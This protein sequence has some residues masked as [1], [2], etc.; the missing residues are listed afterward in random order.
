MPPRKRSSST[1]TEVGTASTAV[2]DGSDLP[3]TPAP[4]T[5][6]TAA[7]PTAEQAAQQGAPTP[8]GRHEGG[9]APH[10]PA[11]ED[12]TA[13]LAARRRAAKSGTIAPGDTLTPGAAPA[14]VDGATPS[15]VMVS[16]TLVA[17]HYGA[18]GPAR[19]GIG[20][21][22][23][24]WMGKPL[25]LPTAPRGADGVRPEALKDDGYVIAD[26]DASEVVI[27]P[28]A[29]TPTSRLLWRKG[30]PVRADLYR[31]VLAAHAEAAAKGE[32]TTAVAAA[33]PP[34]ITDPPIESLTP[35]AQ[36]AV[37]ADPGTI[38]H[39]LA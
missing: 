13:T 8:D 20:G 18:G 19:P 23:G 29:S 28:N 25:V 7:A 3:T 33:L 35:A 27:A 24:V 14:S 9:Q 32:A 2:G 4:E 31:N 10:H 34:G 39:P 17:A 16:Q 38:P 15:A 5:A 21:P 26:C 30:M 12:P 1:S 37:G 36:A 6:P 22:G 11:T